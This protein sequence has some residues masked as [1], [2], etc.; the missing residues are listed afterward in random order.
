VSGSAR[1]EMPFLFT[2]R[3]YLNFILQVEMLEIGVSGS[4]SLPGIRGKITIL[5]GAPA[6]FYPTSLMV[7]RNHQFL[8]GKNA[9]PT[10]E[11]TA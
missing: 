3:D 1:V 10:S 9:T 2:V 5:P 8:P 4:R 6:L 11:E 7:D